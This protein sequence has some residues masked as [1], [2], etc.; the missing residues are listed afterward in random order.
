MIKNCDDKIIRKF[1]AQKD[2]L[3]LS[4]PAKGKSGGIL[5]GVNL[6]SFDVGS[7]KQEEFMCRCRK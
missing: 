6:S 3:W 5:V 2:Y 4:N 7:L 1:D